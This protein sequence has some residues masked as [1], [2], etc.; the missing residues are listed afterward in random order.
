M[1]NPQSTISSQS[2]TPR[3]CVVGSAN[4]DLI[5][6]VPRL[7]KLGET[8]QGHSFHLVYGGKGANQAVMAAKMGASVSMVARVGHDVFG[9]GM[10][11]NF[12]EY[13]IDTTHVTIDMTH[14]SGVAPIFVDD[15][16]QNVI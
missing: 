13:G 12:R 9:E 15:Q 6:R 5:S 8:L 11:T 10:L 16:A 2:A 4:I 3:V 14:S 1:D 7:P